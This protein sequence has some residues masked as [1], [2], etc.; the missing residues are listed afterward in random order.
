MYIFPNKFSWLKN[1][2]WCKC[3]LYF[4]KK[5]QHVLLFNTHK[6]KKF[7]NIPGCSSL[8]WKSFICK[9]I[10]LLEFVEQF[11]NLPAC[12]TYLNNNVISNWTIYDFWSFNIVKFMNINITEAQ[13]PL[14]AEVTN[15]YN[16]FNKH[17]SKVA[18]LL[19]DQ[20]NTPAK[21]PLDSSLI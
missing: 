8:L 1:I 15:N 12:I 18:C 17:T 3:F 20:S 21:V 19:L 10:L 2:H 7:S 5:G 13:L 9:C 4:I 14:K 16:A 6:N 11:T